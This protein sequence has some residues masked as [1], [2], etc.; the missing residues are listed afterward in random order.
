M[1]D[2]QAQ[3]AVLKQT[4]DPAVVDAISQLIEKGDDRQLNRINLL[5]FAARTGLDEERVISAF[6]H[7]ARLGLF[8]LNWNVLCH[9]CGGILETSA[10][11]R[12]GA[13][14]PHCSLCSIRM[15]PT[16]DEMIEV[17]FTVSPAVR[18]IPAHHPESL[19][20]WDYVRQI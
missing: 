1:S 3:F 14:E 9:A 15:K 8:D 7:A 12:Q 5:D 16:L 20:I 17:S 10:H 4:A 11:I 18:P 19:P 2:T 13:D 6:L